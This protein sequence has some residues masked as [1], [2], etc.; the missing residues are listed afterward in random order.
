MLLPFLTDLPYRL[1]LG[2]FSIKYQLLPFQLGNISINYTINE[3][4][5]CS[6]CLSDPTINEPL[7][8]DIVHSI[9]SCPKINPFILKV[10]NFLIDECRIVDTISELDYI[11]GYIDKNKDGLN[12]A[13]LELKKFIFYGYAHDRNIN[14]QFDMYIHEQNK[15]PNAP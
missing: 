4:Y 9:L 11:L 14:S 3:T 5:L 7:R 15:K 8:D 1:S 12:C 2:P 10:F 13:L 6:R